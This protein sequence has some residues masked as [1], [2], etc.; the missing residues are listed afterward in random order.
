MAETDTRFVGP[1]PQVYDALMV[2]MLF[3]PYAL[4]MAAR[5]AALGPDAV[6]ET[7][8]GSG[9]VA[10]ALAPLLRPGTRY[11]VTDLNAP[12]L[13]QARSRQTPAQG[14]RI[15]WAVADALDLPYPD[16]AFDVLCCQFG[17]MFF[18]D[19]RKAYAEARR[20][21]KPGAPFLFSAWDSLAQNDV[22]ATVWAVVQARYADNPP[23]FFNKVPHGY[24]DADVI[25][26]DL[27]A[28]GFSLI[29]VEWIAKESH[30]ARARD[31]A[32][33]LMLGTPFR[34]EMMARDP[35]GLPALV[36]ATEAALIQRYGTGPFVAPTLALVVTAQA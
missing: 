26:A 17:V 18:P 22:P 2:P 28:A 10:R 11:V 16:A 9:V 4:D 14:A 25:R 20:V 5:V 23:Q 36:D 19:R 13:D 12:M 35:D 34:M 31:A 8:A 6:L 3:E 1:V 21:L 27:T 29:N 33:A 7:A 30:V 24:H 15:E 32:E